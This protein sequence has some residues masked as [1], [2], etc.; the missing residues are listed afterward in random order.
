MIG[1]VVIAM[2]IGMGINAIWQP[3]KTFKPG[4]PFTSK[5]L[6][7]FAIIMLGASLSI[8]IILNVGK[9]SLMVMIFTL[10][11][12]FGGDYFIGKALGL[13]WKISNLISAGTGSW[14]APR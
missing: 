14:R 2:F 8:S 12:C 4:L 1:A 13:N 9:L 7:K 11:T 5:K 3:N 6:L 10:T